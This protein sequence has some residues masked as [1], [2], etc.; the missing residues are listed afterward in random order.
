MLSSTK[1]TNYKYFIEIDMDRDLNTYFYIKF[2]K[3]MIEVSFL[4]SD[5]KVI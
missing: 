2:G 4:M 5:V 1:E 3:S